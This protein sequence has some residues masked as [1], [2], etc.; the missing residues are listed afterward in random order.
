MR[1][2]PKKPKKEKDK[3]MA[4]TWNVTITPL[5]V[6]RKEARIVAIRTDDVTSE[7]QSFVILSAIL[8]TPAQKNA[9]VNNLWQQHTEYETRKA[10]IAMYIGSLEEDAETNLEARE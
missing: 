10:Q 7:V 8:D 9:A 6:E 4:I 2:K 5:N 1:T 3:D